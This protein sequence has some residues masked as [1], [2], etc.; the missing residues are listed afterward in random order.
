MAWILLLSFCM[1]S[2]KI[3]VTKEIIL[4]KILTTLV[5]AGSLVL[6]SSADAGVLL[7]VQDYADGDTNIANVLTGDGHMVTSK[8]GG[9]DFATA[10]NADLTSGL[11]GYDAIFWNATAG[12]GGDLHEIGQFTQ[13]L[14][15]V[16]GGGRVFV[17]GYDTIGSPDDPN[18]INFLGGSS[19]SD[20]GGDRDPLAVTGDNSLSTGLIDIIGVIPTGA[21]SD[22]DTMYGL[23]AATTCVAASTNGGCQWSLRSFGAGQIAYISARGSSPLF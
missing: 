15:Y 18:L 9:Y 16:N 19:A 1:Q 5:V 20:F 14:S 4:N 21:W 3:R 11:T 7:Y 8:L 22:W 2:I 17:T 12:G 23:T 10:I 13:L 6:A